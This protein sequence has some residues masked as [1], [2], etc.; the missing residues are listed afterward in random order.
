M[1]VFTMKR[2]SIMAAGALIIGMALMTGLAGC[3]SGVDIDNIDTT[4]T[5]Y[6]LP[7]AAEPADLTVRHEG[8]TAGYAVSRTGNQS[9]VTVSA[10]VSAENVIDTNGDGTLDAVGYPV[11]SGTFTDNF[12]VTYTVSG[13]VRYTPQ[14][15]NNIT[16]YGTVGGAYNASKNFYNT[17]ASGSLSNG[18]ANVVEG[19]TVSYTFTNHKSGSST[20]VNVLDPV[21]SLYVVSFKKAAIDATHTL[22]YRLAGKNT[23]T[24]AF[25]SGANVTSALS[26]AGF[27]VVPVTT[28]YAL[29]NDLTQD[30]TAYDNDL[31]TYIISVDAFLNAPALS[32]GL[33]AAEFEFGV[34]TTQPNCADS[35]TW[36]APTFK[37]AQ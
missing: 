18:V 6:G 30:E 2:L 3:E 4:V 11:L 25:S 13:Y 22:G 1:K 10:T 9:V 35:Y 5:G 23:F 12:G 37:R 19:E 34:L 32:A 26:S 36:I 24:A 20:T 16:F 15:N 33:K 27:S 17:T 14:G 29:K 31:V 8:L 21:A 7:A 28:G